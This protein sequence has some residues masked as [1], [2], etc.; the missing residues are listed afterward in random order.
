MAT[1][2]DE[3]NIN[4]VTDVTDDIINDT[5]SVSNLAS[6]SS[7][8]VL[9]DITL[10]N[11]DDSD[12]EKIDK[13]SNRDKIIKEV[14]SAAQ[15]GNI[16][17]LRYYLEP[18]KENPNPLSVAVTDADGITLVH[19]A[20]LNNKLAT[21]KYLVSLGADPDVRAG[22]MNATP[23]LW[24]VRYGLVYVADWLIREAN[25][26]VTVMD[27]N[28]IG[29]LLA[30]VF[31]SNVM[32]VIYIVWTLNDNNGST[33]F[34]SVGLEGIDFTDPTG[35][36][37]LHWAAYQND[38]LTVDVLIAA[39]AKLDLVDSDGFTPLHW[40]IV[41]GSKAVLTSLVNAKCNVHA[42]TG[43]GKSSWDVASD[44]KCSALW[45]TVL[46]ECNKNPDTGEKIN[47]IMSREWAEFSIFTLPYVTLPLVIFTLTMNISIYFRIFLVLLIL[48][49]QQ[50]SLKKLIMPCLNKGK[51]NIM[52]TPFFAGVFSS[53][54]YWCIITWLFKLLPNTLIGKNISNFLFLMFGSGT[55]YFFI[56]AMLTDPGYIPKQTD[57]KLIAETIYELLSLRQFDSNHFC[58]YSNIRKPLRSKYFKEKKLNIARFDHYCP[59]VY[60]NI[61][62][63]NHKL[64]F[65]F[66]I[67]LEI[68]ICCWL[69][70]A[71]H[72]FDGLNIPQDYQEVCRIPSHS[73]C[74]GFIASNFMFY[75]FIWVLLQSLWLTLLVVVQCVQIS[76][77]LTTYE[78]SHKHKHSNNENIFSSVPVDELSNSD[79]QLN[80][81]DSNDHD[82][83]DSDAEEIEASISDS[84][85][86]NISNNL[87]G[88]R[89]ISV[90]LLFITK[91]LTS[92]ICHIVGLDQMVL[93][94][95]DFI[96]KKK[97]E[98]QN[99]TFNYGFTRNWLD[100]LFLC[101]VGDTYSLETLAA[102]P[103]G[104]EG[105]LNAVLIDYYRL[106]TTPQSV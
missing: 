45:S 101:R 54:A 44:M 58:Q 87:L 18:S 93:V 15:R 57:S 79:N 77:G 106:Y 62:I 24:A 32:M 55:V 83:D 60:N 35:R 21:I 40:G 4:S 92:R 95:N 48:I 105:N 43:N 99:L 86:S 73:L 11:P 42:K 81:D 13:E 46:K 84:L 39:G 47:M 33:T 56:K 17:I 75:F 94:T 37:A 31:S 102:L 34:K 64:F 85:V 36:T 5:Q 49:V 9:H 91:I 96:Q 25:A 90:P 30:S 29:I 100:F 69:N 8:E 52:R 72:Y 67:S 103:V 20:A 14:V 98:S 26:D 10:N 88:K 2:I 6:V 53:V 71:L 82:S 16:D 38:F 65:A 19:W 70:L 61:G 12:Q 28:G 22:D 80:E 63:R 97:L 59:W 66:I 74:N 1:P 68:S 51:I 41:G 7:L 27:K 76:K 78:F 23:L 89:V 3:S 50:L 104:G